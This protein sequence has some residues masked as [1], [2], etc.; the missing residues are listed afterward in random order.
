MLYEAFLYYGRCIDASMI[1]GQK[2]CLWESLFILFPFVF[3][4]CMQGVIRKRKN[5]GNHRCRVSRPAWRVWRSFAVR[6]VFSQPRHFFFLEVGKRWEERHEGGDN[7]S[8]EIREECRQLEPLPMTYS[9][10][11]KKGGNISDKRH[12]CLVT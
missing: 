11:K 2:E 10:G 4:L 9:E 12:V 5:K 3:T 8:E 6:K 7:N 1:D